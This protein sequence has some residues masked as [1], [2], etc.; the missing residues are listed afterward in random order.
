MVYRWKHVPLFRD[1][2]ASIQ[3]RQGIEE[4]LRLL[5]A[6]LGEGCMCTVYAGKGTRL[7]SVLMRGVCASPK[8]KWYS[9]Y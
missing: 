2:S 1:R 8:T 3:N 7:S 4:V 6:L 9:M 5:N